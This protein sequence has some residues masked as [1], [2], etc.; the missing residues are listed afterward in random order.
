MNFVDWPNNIILEVKYS[1][2]L[3]KA[4]DDSMA[5]RFMLVVGNLD[6]GSLNPFGEVAD[7]GVNSWVSWL[8]ATVSPADD[9]G[10]V[11]STVGHGNHGATAVSLATNHVK[12]I[13]SISGNRTHIE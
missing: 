10:K 5:P 1:K 3:T 12:E 9:T 4:R 8:G 13:T 11:L 2:P 6:G 7:F